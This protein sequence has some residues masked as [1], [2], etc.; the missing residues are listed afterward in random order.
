VVA[1]FA[2][3]VFAGTASA[4]LTAAEQKWAAPLV[5]A[6]NL[7]NAGLHLVLTQ[8]SRNGALVAGEKPDNLNLTR[9]LA[10]LA[11]CQS[12]KVIPKA[13]KPPT[14]RLAGFGDSLNAAC[15]HDS[16]G[17]N[18]FAKAIGSVTKNKAAQAKAF[19]AQGVAEFKKG[20]DQLQKAYNALTAIGGANA[21]KA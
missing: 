15:I 12:G 3:A 16:N 10:V 11:S 2:A 7:Q 5:Q 1:V 8:A 14:A 18:D 9:T 21:F 19:L 20:S 4:K 6:W 17:A 13:G